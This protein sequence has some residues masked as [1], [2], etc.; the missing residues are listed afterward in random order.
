MSKRNLF[1][2]LLILG[3]TIVS[4]VKVEAASSSLPAI[5]RCE[6]QGV[7]KVVGYLVVTAKDLANGGTELDLSDA[8]GVG[9]ISDEF[10]SASL[11]AF[12]A[13]GGANYISIVLSQHNPGMYKD[14]SIANREVLASQS[15]VVVGN[16]PVHLSAQG[17]LTTDPT[18]LDCELISGVQ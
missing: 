6:F 14:G 8:P 18:S 9:N 13:S 11:H 7:N 10:Y 16:S 12:T 2:V 15:N 4:G 1:S 17:T 5:Y 3:I